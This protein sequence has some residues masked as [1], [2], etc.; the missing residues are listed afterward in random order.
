[1]FRKC[2]PIACFLSAAFLEATTAEWTAMGSPA[3]WDV[4][5]NW[6]PNTAFPNATDD[7]ANLT[8]TSP[9]IP[10]N[11]FI[12]I[13]MAQ[14][15]IT[16][17]T[18]NIDSATNYTIQQMG[19]SILRFSVSSGSA[20]LN[21]TASLGNGMH[22]FT[23]PIS[24]LSSLVVSQGSTSDLTITN[25]I[26]GGPTITLTMTAPVNTNRLV[27]SGAGVNTYGGGTFINSG[28][29]SITADNKLGV[30]V[31]TPSAVTIGGGTLEFAGSFATSR[32]FTL[33]GGAS[34][35]VTG[36]NTA[37]INSVISGAGSLT[38]ANTG[39]LVLT[40]T[41]TYQ[42]GTLAGAGVLEISS[43]ANLGDSS[44]SL[45]I[46]SATLRTNGSINSARSGSLTGAAV[47]D[48]FGNSSTFS[49]NFSGSGS[50]RVTNSGAGVPTIQLVGSNSYSG[51][52]LVDPNTHLSGTT[53]GLQGNITLNAA[54]SLVTFSQNFDGTYSGAIMG[55]VL[56]QLT[57]VG[58]GT[59][60]FTGTSPFMGTTSI[61]EGALI[62]NGS[63]ANSPMTVTAA[64]TLGGFGTVGPT[65]NFGLIDPGVGTTIGTLTINGAL[66]YM[67]AA[68]RTNINIAP[69]ASDE[70]TVLGGATILGSLQIEPIP[71]FYGFSA[72]YTILTSTGLVG[73]FGPVTSTN[74]AFAP[75]VTYTG[76]TAL[77]HVVISEPFATFPFS[78]ANTAAVGNN[79]DEL[80]AANQLSPDLFN[81]FN[82]FVGE[83]ND[84]I[85]AAL[86]EMHPAPYTAFT[87]M[88]AELDGQLISLFHRLP[89]LPCSCDNPSRLWI[90]GLGNTLTMK[91]H[92]LEIGFQANTGG[93]AFGYDGQINEY[94][95][96]GAGGAWTRSHLEWHDHRGD[97]DVNG[98]Y[99]GIY[100]DT[101]ADSFY[102][103]ASFLAGMDFYETNRHLQFVTTDRHAHA[104]FQALDLIGQISTAY[105]FGSPQ[106]YFYPYANIDFIYL[107][108]HKFSESGADGLDLNVFARSDET[109]RSELGLALQV[110]DRNAAETMCI[111]PLVSIG[112]V[113]MC[114]I[115]RPKPTATFKGASIPFSVFGWDESWNLFNI[116]FD[117]SITYRC[118][119]FLI[120]YNAEFSPDSHTILFNQHG[121]IRLDWKW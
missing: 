35:G 29:L 53:N 88:Q 5:A 103:G 11:P 8:D 97:G 40:G 93:L 18:L 56:S 9:P 47:I 51:G 38:K 12:N 15:T 85:N 26:T 115:Q 104:S 45:S 111:S 55:P 32:P 109:L 117:L 113:N 4:A 86:D 41:N 96:M 68:A 91:R 61:N 89:Y 43:D 100:F 13:A 54:S 14:P 33:T 95:V 28:V 116:N 60:T 114:P 118:Y 62:V 81:V 3:D 99:G 108:T 101:Q 69:L 39:T 72:D 102:L 10:P 74:P 19:A 52:T 107:H 90:E 44:G 27:L 84:T 105:L 36:A 17:G 64:G 92:G 94:F 37:T 31:P 98:L 76:T 79:I 83:S 20:A 77:L 120:G 80:Y 67:G 63:L 23:V 65:M 82:S 42:G 71:A 30:L 106:A 87:E 121:N 2:I 59:V 66:M 75:F 50:L 73:T 7:V 34:I 21:V 46:A 22:T 49:G 24:L 16:V 78:N 70:I 25:N 58:S 119:S 112:W 110:Q 48:L 6:N 1:M 57:K